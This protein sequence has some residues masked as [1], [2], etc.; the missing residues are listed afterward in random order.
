MWFDTY[1]SKIWFTRNYGL[2]DD[3]AAL[4]KQGSYMHYFGGG[5]LKIDHGRCLSEAG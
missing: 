2:L 4:T 5:G 1:C 3:P